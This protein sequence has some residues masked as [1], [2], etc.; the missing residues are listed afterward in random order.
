VCHRT[1]ASLQDRHICLQHSQ[2]GTQEEIVAEKF[3][4]KKINEAL[5]L[6]NELAKEKKAELR[7]MV[8][9][10]YSHLKS[11][12]EGAS[13]RAGEEARDTFTHGEETVKEFVSAIDESVHKNPWAYLGGTALGFLIIGHLLARRK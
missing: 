7:G 8:S 5:D 11:A 2:H 10:K 13:G 12:L 4:D 3:E 9:E 6:L 1:E